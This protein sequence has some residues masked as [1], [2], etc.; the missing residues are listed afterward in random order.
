M[1]YMK[2]IKGDKGGIS[3][4]VICFCVKIDSKV[5]VL[6]L[7]LVWWMILVTFMSLITLDILCIICLDVLYNLMEIEPLI[8]K[9]LDLTFS[10]GPNSQQF[11]NI[12]VL[13]Q[14]QNFSDNVP[15][16]NPQ[17]KIMKMSA[18]PLIKNLFAYPNISLET[19]VYVL[20]LMSSR[21][22]KTQIYIQSYH[23][24]HSQTFLLLKTLHS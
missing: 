24:P 6:E 9:I 10:S 12:S 3:N 20:F 22:Q 13:V 5:G 14:G 16:S 17:I 23:K 19:Q 15:T 4:K 8:L 18:W 7:R 1:Q 2:N 11:V 21:T